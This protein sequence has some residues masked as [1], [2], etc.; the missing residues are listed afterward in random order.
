[1]DSC[2]RV[3]P[4]VGDDTT[5]GGIDRL[6]QLILF[7]REFEARLKK[8][9]VKLR[10]FSLTVDSWMILV[11]LNDKSMSQNQIATQAQRSRVTITRSMPKLLDLGYATR[12]LATSD[13]RRYVVSIT[14][15][16]R[17]IVTMSI[18]AILEGLSSSGGELN[19]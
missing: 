12:R 4:T 17:E 13:K 16:G 7:T 2:T 15:L 10:P 6:W 9:A 1:V 5:R 8:I 11:V 14:D 18:S 19:P 3:V